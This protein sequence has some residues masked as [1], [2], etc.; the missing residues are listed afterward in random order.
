VEQLAHASASKDSVA[1]IFPSVNVKTGL[2]IQCLG[3]SNEQSVA[4][5]ELDQ[6]GLK[7]PKANEC[8]ESDLKLF[9]GHRTSPAKGI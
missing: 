3:V 4:T 7:G 8:A 9:F 5:Q 1:L 6:K 2:N